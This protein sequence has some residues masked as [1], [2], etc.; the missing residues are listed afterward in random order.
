[1]VLATVIAPILPLLTC[2]CLAR[3]SSDSEFNLGTH[4]AF[5]RPIGSLIFV[6]PEA[7]K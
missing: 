6:E 4:L 5:S 3:R 2:G 7:I 1:M